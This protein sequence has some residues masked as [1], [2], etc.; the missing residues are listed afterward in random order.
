MPSQEIEI[1]L[2]VMLVCGQ[3][4]NEYIP[5]ILLVSVEIDRGNSAKQKM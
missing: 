1:P 5:L 4:L 3:Q 2:D